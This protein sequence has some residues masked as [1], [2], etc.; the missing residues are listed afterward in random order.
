MG[1]DPDVE[2]TVAL[3][4]Y[5]RLTEARRSIQDNSTARFN[6]FLA[7]AS[8]ATAV[9]A[10]LVGTATR[11]S[12]VRAGVVTAIGALV[13]LLGL[14]VFARQVEFNDRHRRYAVAMTALRTYLIRRSP[15][16]APFVLMPTLDD[17]GPFAP[18]PFRRHWLRDAVGLAGT[19]GLL[20][21]ALI[22]VGAAAGV[23]AVGPAWLAVGAG[24][25]LLAGSVAL[26]VGYVRRRVAR[27]AAEVG[28]VLRRRPELAPASAAEPAGGS[29][30]EQAGPVQ[31]L[32]TRASSSS[33]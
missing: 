18:E 16:L 7:V 33:T 13:L 3:T 22:G 14:S 2:L 30:S 23:L 24:V 32:T 19:V 9:S 28:A 17:P 15:G 5:E 29:G 21:S 26:H 25:A 4:E 27:S 1:T 31:T 10:G 20:N 12:P 8:A 11:F 6:F